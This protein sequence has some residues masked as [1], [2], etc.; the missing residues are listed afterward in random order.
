MMFCRFAFDCTY[1]TKLK[2]SRFVWPIVTWKL[3]MCAQASPYYLELALFSLGS[4]PNNPKE[5]T[6]GTRGSYKEERRG[7]RETLS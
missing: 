5:E 4:S 7:T 6:R 3:C 1:I 2:K